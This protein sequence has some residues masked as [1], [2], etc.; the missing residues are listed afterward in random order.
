M[1]NQTKTPLPKNP[2]T[3]PATTPWW[4]FTLAGLAYGL[5]TA[6]AFPPVDLWPLAFVSIL[7]LIWASCRPMRRPFVAAIFVWLGAIP[8]WVYEQSWL[9]NVTAAGYPLLCLYLAAYA[10]VF[11]WLVGKIRLWRAR[12][13]RAPIPMSLLAPLLWV[14]LEVFKGEVALTGYAWFLVGH[15]LIAAPVLVFPATLLGQYFISFL[16]AALAG[17][18][19]DLAGW[20]NVSR[21]VGPIAAAAIAIIWA[22]T[23]W[24]GAIP[25]P[26]T[27]GP[28]LRI[29]VV[30]T[31][32]PQSNKIAWTDAQQSRDWLEFEALTRR[33]AQ[34]VPPRAVIVWPETMFPGVWLNIEADKVERPWPKGPTETVLFVDRLRALQS[35]VGAPMI[36]GAPA[37]DGLRIAKSPSGDHREWDARYNSVF[38]VDSAGIHPE[39]YDKIDLTPFGEVI[40]YV[41]RWKGLQDL[42]MDLG[43]GGMRFDLA[44][45]TREMVFQV[46]LD[47]ASPAATVG[48][49]TPICFEATRSTLCRRLVYDRARRRASVM[50]NL[51]NDG[52]FA[53]SRAG[54]GAHLL[55]ARWRCVELG[56]PMVR[57]VNTG[58]SASIDSRGQLRRAGPE[59]AARD[60]EVAGIL[61]DDVPLPRTDLTTLYGRVGNGFGW[62]VLAAAALFPILIALTSRRG[63]GVPGRA[64]SVP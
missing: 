23:A 18:A 28:A 50:M 17:A 39:R 37:M 57:A 63:L 3:P 41:W 16:V 5:L 64:N 56:V 35:E 51:S 49:V 14:G 26:P 31:N 10:G 43:A 58:I 60:S 29:A 25:A 48:I 52:W 21:R 33:A 61:T 9:I 45:G 46:P 7:P 42:V 55:A 54:R 12:A 2:A 62:T 13:G 6:L 24:L 38:L 15:P 30:Q 36:V 27:G 44:S 8:V 19:G 53:H 40:P 11:V 4:T 20:S 34:A 47:P 1:T 22:A 32:V 59:N